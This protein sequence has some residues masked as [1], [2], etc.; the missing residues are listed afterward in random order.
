MN[1]GASQETIACSCG[2]KIIRPKG[3]HSYCYCGAQISP[4]G[5]ITGNDVKEKSN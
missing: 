4:E 1:A 5:K 2:K 3:S